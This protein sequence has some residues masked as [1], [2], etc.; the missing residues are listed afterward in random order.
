MD[1]NGFYKIFEPNIRKTTIDWRIYTLVQN[2]VI[3]RIGR[4][5]YTLKRGVNFAQK[6]IWQNTYKVF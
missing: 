3:S 4:G 5:K 6:F 1:A 2:S